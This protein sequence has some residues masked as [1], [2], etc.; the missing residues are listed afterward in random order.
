VELLYEV[1]CHL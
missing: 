1:L